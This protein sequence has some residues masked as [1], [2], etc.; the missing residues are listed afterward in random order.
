MLDLGAVFDP[1]MARRPP[2]RR[3]I[4]E[5]W[6]LVTY[7]PAPPNPAELPNGAGRAVLVI[8]AFL[9]GDSLTHD[10]RRFLERCGFKAFGWG[11]GVNWGPTTRLLTGLEQR[12][13][14]LCD[15]HGPIAVIGISLGGLLARNLAYER[16]HDIR[17]VVTIASP[18]RLPT[19]TI[20]E[21][22]V[23]ICAQHYSPAVQPERLLTPLPVPSTMIWSRDDGIVPWDSCWVD[24]ADGETIE[25]SGAH[26][27]L[28]SN[29]ATL[30]AVVRRLAP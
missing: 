6:S 24:D 22:L 2:P 13:D 1:D 8:P 27:S 25:L 26:L 15:V 19:A 17:H 30:R 21:P 20:M 11:L 5:A 28:C 18:F 10:L 16:P 12:V 4:D 9:N 7:H 29:P 14:E 3:L 23:R